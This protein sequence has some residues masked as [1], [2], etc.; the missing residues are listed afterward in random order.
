MAIK[1]TCGCFQKALGKTTTLA[2]FALLLQDQKKKTLMIDF[3][4]AAKLTQ[5]FERK[6]NRC[7]QDAHLSI[8]ESLILDD[9]SFGITSLTEYL[10]MIPSNRDFLTLPP[11]THR[12]LPD[13]HVSKLLDS[14]EENYDFILLDIPSVPTVYTN[15]VF[16]A[17]DYILPIVEPAR[18]SGQAFS[19]LID[20]IVTTSQKKNKNLT[21]LGIIE[22]TFNLETCEGAFST[23]RICDERVQKL[24]FSKM[25]H[26][27]LSIHFWLS[28]D[29]PWGEIKN[30]KFLSTFTTLL[31]EVQQRLK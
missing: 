24:L 23:L 15:H 1:L 10:D 21:V 16:V 22:S 18:I 25:I 3:D 20:E 30:Y 5:I 11:T 13:Q 7:L 4:P 17:S 12:K 2:V 19:D 9:L 6:F 29:Q 28:S 26:N 31:E 14:I 8:F 27:R